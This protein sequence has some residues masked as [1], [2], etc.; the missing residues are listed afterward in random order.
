MPKE[1]ICA[2]RIETLAEIFE[3]KTHNVSYLIHPPGSVPEFL[4]LSG[5]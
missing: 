2:P 1:V 5:L 3:T 4:A